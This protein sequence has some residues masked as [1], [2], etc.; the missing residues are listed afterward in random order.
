MP[1][2][3][4]EESGYPIGVIAQGPTTSNFPTN[5]STTS[6]NGGQ[7][8]EADSFAVRYENVGRNAGAAGGYNAAPPPPQQQFG[9]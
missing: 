3:N 5:P 4:R 1:G 2:Y 6:S 8:Q 7:T 9:R